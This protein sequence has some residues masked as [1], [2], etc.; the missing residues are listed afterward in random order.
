ML[1]RSLGRSGS[2]GLMK[3]APSRQSLRRNQWRTETE[4]L[5]GASGAG[6]GPIG[7]LALQHALQRESNGPESGSLLQLA[8][9]DKESYSFIRSTGSGQSTPSEVPTLSRLRPRNDTPECSRG[10]SPIMPRIVPDLFRAA[11]QEEL[12]KAVQPGPTKRG[13]VPKR[14]TFPQVMPT[15]SSLRPPALQ[16]APPRVVSSTNNADAWNGSVGGQAVHGANHPNKLVSAFWKSRPKGAEA[17]VG[18][19]GPHQVEKGG[20]QQR[21]NGL[22]GDSSIR[23]DSYH[24]TTNGSITLEGFDLTITQSGMRHSSDPTLTSPLRAKSE[25]P[26]DQRLVLLGKLGK[27]ASGMVYKAFDLITLK[28][29]AIKV[30]PIHCRAQRRQLVHE[31]CSLYDSLK[32]T[33]GSPASAGSRDSGRSEI[34][35]FLDA[36][37]QKEDGSVSLMVEYM[38]GGSLQDLADKGGCQDEATLAQM[39]RQCLRGLSFLHDSQQLHRDIKPANILINHKGRCK[40]SDFGIT[41]KLGRGEDGL[42]PSGGSSQGYRISAVPVPAWTLPDI[43]PL[44]ELY[45]NWLFVWRLRTSLTHANTFIGT[46]TYMSPERI[47]GLDYSYESDIWSLGLSLL[48]TCLGRLPLDTKNGFW[49]VLSAIRDEPAPALPEDGDWSDDIRSFISLCLT[50]EPELRP[51]CTTLLKHPFVAAAETSLQ[52]EMAPV[53]MKG[54][55]RDHQLLELEEVL[56]GVAQHLADTAA[57]GKKG[58]E[59]VLLGLTAVRD[60]DSTASPALAGLA[61]QLSLP[62]EACRQ[63]AG[64]MVERLIT[65]GADSQATL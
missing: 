15:N 2:D 36:F 42:E 30:I 12:S 50:K 65:N 3:A 31:L 18:F 55:V 20:S 62:E 13:H 51:D 35:E 53:E 24:F 52:D 19:E 27:G 11:S 37:A 16:L 5:A 43:H 59:E 45:L 39:A 47:M 32:A 21:L 22:A 6:V 38:D 25:V 64:A 58:I 57:K 4:L 7:I 49:T 9:L 60:S 54:V 1:R 56:E 14:S 41:R 17:S 33:P 26:M 29:V 63:K 34:V 44:T 46:T 40:V 48:S 23:Q 61:D 28:L 8:A 10:S